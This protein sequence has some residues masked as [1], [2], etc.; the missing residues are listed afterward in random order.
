MTA[1]AVLLF[2]GGMLIG[3]GLGRFDFLTIV[4]GVALAVAGWRL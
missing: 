1:G 2:L 3:A 4:S